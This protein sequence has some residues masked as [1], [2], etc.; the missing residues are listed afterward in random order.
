MKYFI[1]FFSLAFFNCNTKS[2]DCLN[3]KT[4]T[5]KHI[6]LIDD[7][8]IITRNDSIQVEINK[9][10]GVKYTGTIEWLS[11]CKYLLTYT[12]VNDDSRKNVI[13]MKI[14]V[15]IISVTD[16]SYKY[17]A[18]NDIQKIKGKLVKLK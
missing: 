5:F 7:N 10:T 15:D 8:T 6:D 2:M 12:D 14:Y 17:S 4:G 3:F 18:Y 16:S 9:N 13:G 11:D 1:L